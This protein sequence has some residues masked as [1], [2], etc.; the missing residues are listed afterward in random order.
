MDRMKHFQELTFL[1]YIFIFFS[2]F[3]SGVGSFIRRK[4]DGI[5][6]KKLIMFL[7]IDII[8]SLSVGVPTFLLVYGYTDNMVIGAGFAS[9][10]GHMGPR[11]IYF[12]ELIIAEKLNSQT[13]KDAINKHYN[14]KVLKT[15][16]DE[17]K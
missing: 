4:K 12:M 3:L 2:I 17:N 15:K 10:L 9:V 16:Q 14:S 11:G 13:L 5:G 7:W 1:D 8:G 6:I